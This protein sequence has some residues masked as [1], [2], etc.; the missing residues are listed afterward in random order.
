MPNL[1]INFATEQRSLTAWNPILGFSLLVA[2][3]LALGI[4]AWDYRQQADERL[5]LQG[6]R[7]VLHQSTQRLRTG[8]PIPPEM[9]AQV[10][11][12]NTAYALIQTPWEEIFTAL[13]AA[14]GKGPGDAVPPSVKAY[15]AKRELVPAS[16]AKDFMAQDIARG[17]EPGGIALLSVKADA[18][19]RE[20]ILSGEAR[21]FTALSAFT[22]ALSSIPIF[23]NISLVNDKL[24]AGNPPVVV[25][26]D[27][28]LAWRAQ[29]ISSH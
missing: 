17:K 23:Q 7:D 4:A 11:Q 1:S 14:R 29:D 10:E 16:G 24:S 25:A 19:K 2:G 22:S 6:R 21:D 9:A 26:F 15:T 27:L 28:R 18:A 3:A 8:D 5:N 20:L 13:E 12:A